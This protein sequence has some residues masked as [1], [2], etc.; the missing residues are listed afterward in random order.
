LRN[1]VFVPGVQLSGT[2]PVKEGALQT[3]TI[4]VTG[5]TA[6]PGTVTV[7]SASKQ[8]I[9]TLGGKRFDVSL[10]TVKL[11]RVTPAASEWPSRPV[12]FPL[13]GLLEAHPHAR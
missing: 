8:V 9:G 7:G 13:A 5:T 3:A 4:R 10:A 6:S 1:L 11:S 2:I 12:S